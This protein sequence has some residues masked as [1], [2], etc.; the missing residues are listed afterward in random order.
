MDGKERTVEV[1]ALS[2]AQF[3]QATKS[4]NITLADLLAI[5]RKL[6][7][8]NQA[9]ENDPNTPIPK[10]IFGESWDLFQNLADKAVKDPP[11]ILER[12]LPNEEIKIASKALEMSQPPKN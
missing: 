3:R 12:I 1:Y 2:S 8:Y 10:E 5:W 11:N 6:D 7:E 4:A 9:R